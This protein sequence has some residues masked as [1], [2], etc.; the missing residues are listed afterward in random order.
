MPTG[1]W[2]LR[3]F[4]EYGE[5]PPG[6]VLPAGVVPSCIASE[7][8]K[9]MLLFGRDES[10]QWC[11]PQGNDDT[12]DRNSV[13]V[14]CRQGGE[15][16]CYALGAPREIKTTYFDTG[17]FYQP[18]KWVA[19]VL[20]MG[21]LDVATREAIVQR[22]R[23]NLLGAFG[24][25]PRACEAGFSELRWCD[26]F[27]VYKAIDEHC[28][29]NGIRVPSF[30]D[31]FRFRRWCTEYYRMMAGDRQFH[32]F[33]NANMSPIPT[34]LA[35]WQDQRTDQ[36]G[37]RFKLEGGGLEPSSD[38]V[39]YLLINSAT[40]LALTKRASQL[41]VEPSISPSSALQQWSFDPDGTVVSV[42]DATVLDID[43]AETEAGARVIMLPLRGTPSQ[44][45]DYRVADGKIVSRLNG[46]VLQVDMGANHM[47]MMQASDNSVPSNP[48]QVWQRHA[49][50]DL[51]GIP[52][53]YPL[54]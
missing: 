23:W 12:T 30:G 36:I 43:G 49:L 35:P 50:G 31:G 16:T 25:P 26:A 51:L 19:Y 53:F 9:P 11:H 10:G 22:H 27:D 13:M 8:G 6:S 41:R 33:C 42:A 52:S 29:A 39:S 24:R 38:K 1:R 20:K 18:G 14:A 48:N 32:A 28:G 21:T 37:A 17:Q 4:A 54:A 2:C 40:R 45:W 7:I 44:L 46:H 34:P 3:C 15:K 5:W 47:V